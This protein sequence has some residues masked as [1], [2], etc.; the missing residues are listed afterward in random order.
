MKQEINEYDVDMSEEFENIIDEMDDLDMEE[1]NYGNDDNLIE[2]HDPFNRRWGFAPFILDYDASNEDEFSYVV[3]AKAM[4]SDKNTYTR[5]VQQINELNKNNDKI[6]INGNFFDA[7]AFGVEYKKILADSDKY[8][9]KARKDNPDADFEE[10][11][12]FAQEE[13]DAALQSLVDDFYGP[14][15]ALLYPLRDRI[16]YGVR[17]NLEAKF[18][19]K[20]GFDPLEK[21]FTSMGIGDRYAKDICLLN[22]KTKE[23]TIKCLATEGGGQF[24]QNYYRERDPMTTLNNVMKIVQSQ[25]PLVDF[26]IFNTNRTSGDYIEKRA[27][28][29]NKKVKEQI[30]RYIMCPGY[31]DFEGV[32]RFQ[33]DGSN[34]ELNNF[35]RYVVDYDHGRRRFSTLSVD[36]DE[37]RTKKEPKSD[38]DKAVENYEKLEKK[39]SVSNNRG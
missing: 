26:V 10:L 11:E 35:K 19:Q 27:Y 7:F 36:Y 37:K 21:L 39:M 12:E 4:L 14:A 20:F 2:R 13:K 32:T 24:V 16:V 8:L 30:T 29:E 34:G 9:E 31:R 15:L 18:E 5:F 33:N 28:V 38:Y 25:F 23:E 22:I 17:G 1:P 6:F 3:M